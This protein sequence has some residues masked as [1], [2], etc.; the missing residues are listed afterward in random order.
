[1]HRHCA[2]Q[3]C[4]VRLKVLELGGADLPLPSIAQLVEDR[5]TG[6]QHLEA[7]RGDLKALAAGVVGVCFA[8]DV[9]A[10]L[11][12]CDRFRRCLFGD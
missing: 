6:A 7:E 8:C 11:Q 9:S 2:N 12:N 1:M 5:F 10:L 3:L 4:Q